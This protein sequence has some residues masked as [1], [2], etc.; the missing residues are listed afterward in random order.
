MDLFGNETGAA[1]S[2]RLGLESSGKRLGF[3][4]HEQQ[5]PRAREESDAGSAL[6]RQALCLLLPIEWSGYFFCRDD[7][8]LS[9][10]LLYEALLYCP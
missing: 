2:S 3:A 6:L 7:R 8:H 4:V 9:P 1:L 10:N 5:L